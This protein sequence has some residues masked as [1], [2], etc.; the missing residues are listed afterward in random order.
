MGLMP[1]LG[2]GDFCGYE[3]SARMAHARGVW[4]TRWLDDLHQEQDEDDEQD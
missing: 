4:A 2:V 3:L 1:S